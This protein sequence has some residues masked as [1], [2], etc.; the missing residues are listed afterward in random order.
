M[1]LPGEGIWNL[2]RQNHAG[3]L[4]EKKASNKWSIIPRLRTRVYDRSSIRR[5]SITVSK[6]LF[7]ALRHHILQ[8]MPMHIGKPH[9]TA[10]EAESK[11]VVVNA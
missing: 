11:G 10:A 2:N 8:Y 4:L 3:V 9:I 1:K 6:M 5:R 7:V